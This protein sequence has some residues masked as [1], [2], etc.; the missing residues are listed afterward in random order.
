MQRGTKREGASVVRAAAALV[1]CCAWP[2]GCGSR[3]AAQPE[4]GHPAHAVSAVVLVN[5]CARLGKDNAGL[6]EAAIN[7]LVDGCGSFSGDA[8]R[9]TATLLPSGAIQFEPRRDQSQAIPVCVLHHPLTHRVRLKEACTLDVKL[10]AGSMQVSKSSDA[11][12]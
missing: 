7:Q 6:A 4:P 5:G 8:V 1:A 10:E 12:S 9:F 2:C 3:P 11:G